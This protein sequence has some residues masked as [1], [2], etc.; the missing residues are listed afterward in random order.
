MDSICLSPECTNIAKCKGLCDKHYRRLKKWGSIDDLTIEDIPGEVWKSIEGRDR[1]LISTEGRV[2]SIRTK[3]ERLLTPG[4]HNRSLIITDN[5]HKSNIIVHME[6]LR[7]F[8]PNPDNDSQPYFKDGDR[9]NCKLSNLQWYG[10]NSLITRAIEMAEGSSSKWA[11]CFLKFWHGDIR[12]LDEFFEE[13][14]QRLTR[15]IKKKMNSMD[16]KWYFDYEDLV[17]NALVS[18]FIS[19]KRG[20]ISDLTYINAWMFTILG[21][22]IKVWYKYATPLYSDIVS[23]DGEDYS[24]LDYEGYC[25][26]S[27]ELEM[28]FR[29]LLET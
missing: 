18:A 14:R 13:M 16:L 15:W 2:K 3:H 29:Q 26:P 7:A 21:N 24:I 1:I 8:V 4:F 19:I 17:Q 22:I 25:N 28:E 20:M 9:T 27:A 5:F 23:K 6:V 10:Y 11:D 12:A